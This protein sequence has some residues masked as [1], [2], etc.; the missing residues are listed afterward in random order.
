MNNHREPACVIVGQDADTDQALLT[1]A[2]DRPC[3]ACHG[4]KSTKRK[5]RGAEIWW[6]SLSMFYIFWVET[7]FH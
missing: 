1:V 5:N 3:N 4:K 6:L 7:A 2:E